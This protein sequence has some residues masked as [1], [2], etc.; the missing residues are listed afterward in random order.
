MTSQ[1]LSPQDDDADI[2]DLVDVK[3][4][5][6]K[7]RN[8]FFSNLNFKS[9]KAP[10]VPKP[11][12]PKPTLD[13]TAASK[14]PLG[15]PAGKRLPKEPGQA[16]PERKAGLAL[17]T[18]AQ[19]R[20]LIPMVG[21]FLLLGAVSLYVNFGNASTTRPA[22][23]FVMP[24]PGQVGYI[25]APG[26]MTTS[27]GTSTPAGV[28]AG[29]TP[30]GSAAAGFMP[31]AQG[32]PGAATPVPVTRS[33]SSTDATP[34]VSSAPPPIPG[35]TTATPG[36][37]ASPSKTVAVAGKAVPGNTTQ[38][39]KPATSKP[40]SSKPGT[41]TKTTTAAATVPGAP[42]KPAPAP[43][44]V[45]TQ[46]IIPDVF[47]P[48][49]NKNGSAANAGSTGRSPTGSANSGNASGAPVTAQPASLRNVPLAA[50]PQQVQ[51]ARATP[52][53]IQSLPAPV[54]LPVQ[55]NPP[56][57]AAPVA[58]PTP[59]RVQTLPQVTQSM[60]LPAPVTAQTP[61]GVTLTKGGVPVSAA[62]PAPSVTLVGT[63]S[64]DTP[65]AILA[66]PDGQM[67][68]GIGDHVTVNK[69]D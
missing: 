37:T 4:R 63:A 18:T 11:T 26:T 50:P 55:A 38:A 5:D 8:A 59:V 65:T 42:G 25:P 16:R 49:D 9:A 32:S 31:A 19:Q 61:S 60:P 43:T 3:P 30:P 1:P 68:A 33:A 10:K 47:S 20:K 51:I 12:M 7:P 66:T 57:S 53:S 6:V 14:V 40:E 58:L 41:A 29:V 48:A 23:S 22:T 44:D 28:T 39:S 13:K 52:L 56:L 35:T 67:I 64:G 24:G 54:P 46:P 27:A 62:P 69:L 15:R 21:V 36:G 17:A 34:V 45:P 2:T